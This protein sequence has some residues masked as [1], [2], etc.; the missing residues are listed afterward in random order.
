MS[1]RRGPKVEPHENPLIENEIKNN[2]EESGILDGLTGNIDPTV[3]ELFESEASY[4]I[5]EAPEINTLPQPQKRK[6]NINELNQTE[7]RMF[8]KTGF[9]PEI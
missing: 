8:H 6:K 5:N 4:I 2:W 7:L 1:T 3:A 9:L